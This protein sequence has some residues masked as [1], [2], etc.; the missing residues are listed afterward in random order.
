MLNESAKLYDQFL[1]IA[2]DPKAARMMIHDHLSEIPQRL[3]NVTLHRYQCAQGNCTL[4]RV[5]TVQG[6]VFCWTKDYKYSSGM[7]EKLT[8]E[9][10]RR[11]NTLN[12][13]DHWPSHVFDLGELAEFVSGTSNTASVPMVCRHRITNVDVFEILK[14]IEGVRAGNPGAPTRI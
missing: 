4:A 2:G 10:A 14:T 3:N 7:N 9:S 12:G 13:K 8:V 11:K 6:H 5:F 1:A